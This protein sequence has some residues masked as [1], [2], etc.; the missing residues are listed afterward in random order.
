MGTVLHHSTCQAGSARLGFRSPCSTPS[1]VCRNS[2]PSATSIA[3]W[4]PLHASTAARLEQCHWS[5]RLVALRLPSGV[6]TLRCLEQ[7]HWSFWLVASRLPPALHTLNLCTSCPPTHPAPH[8][9]FSLR[10][11]T[12][13][14]F[15]SV[16][17]GMSAM[18]SINTWPCSCQCWVACTWLCTCHT[19]NLLQTA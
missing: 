4:R 2:S 6:H 5:F 8:R 18:A 13:S 9:S 11:G 1:S 17:P 16:P 10:A 14:A 19:H 7:C 3:T 12:W 15:W